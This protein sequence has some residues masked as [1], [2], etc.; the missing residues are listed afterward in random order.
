MCSITLRLSAGPE[1]L[2][3]SAG[4]A[5]PLMTL[6]RICWSAVW[7]VFLSVALIIGVYMRCYLHRSHQTSAQ[8]HNAMSSIQSCHVVH[9]AF[10]CEIWLEGPW[11]HFSLCGAANGS[12]CD[13]DFFWKRTTRLL[14][15]LAPHLWHFTLSFTF[16]RL[17]RA[18]WHLFALS[19]I[20]E[21][22]FTCWSG[23]GREN[24]KIQK[25]NLDTFSGETGLHLQAG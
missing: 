5:Y 2:P 3:H 18:T 6:I 17:K 11:A 1:L 23:G 12:R 19:G 21:N 13:V 15:L 16:S 4:A 24:I 9:F 7:Q 25:W 14:R 22:H 8:T 20:S 10:F